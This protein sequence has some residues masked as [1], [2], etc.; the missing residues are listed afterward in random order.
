[1]KERL[2]QTLQLVRLPGLKLC[3][4]EAKLQPLHPF[5]DRLLNEHRRLREMMR[6]SYAQGLTRD[7]GLIAEDPTSDPG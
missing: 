6:E 4:G 1:M 3:K 7:H 5:H 2:N